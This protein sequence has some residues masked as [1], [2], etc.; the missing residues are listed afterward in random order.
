LPLLGVALLAAAQ[1][2]APVLAARRGERATVREA[3]A[4]LRPGE[5]AGTLLLGGFRGLACDFL[6]LR[7]VNAKQDGR[8][9][10]SVALAQAIVRVQPR[11]EQIWEFLAW[12]LSANLGAEYEA[13]SDKWAWFQE[14]LAANTEG[15]ARNPHSHRLVRHLAWMFFHRGDEFAEE[16]AARRWDT[17]FGPA[18]V[19]VAAQLP[20]AERPA[21]L[22]ETPGLRHFELASRLYD[23]AQRLADARGERQSPFVRRS[24]AI[25]LDHDGNRL[26]AEGQHRAALAR[27]LDALIAWDRVAAWSAERARSGDDL[28]I[29]ALD[30]YATHE[31]RLRRKALSLVRALAPDA[32]A[33]DAAAADLDARRFAALQAR[34][35]AAGW[36]TT[37]VAGR[38]RWLDRQ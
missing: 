20:A 10:E 14:G 11:F 19:A 22:P 30:I 12:D 36:R 24:V 2:L 6:W 33:A 38:I 7:A 26:R 37:A 32:A 4:V 8:H 25:A 18:L 15:I 5:L 29:D 28:A 13:R 1:V 16:I 35:D 9:Y 27:Y 34:L 23:L 31:G 17:L 3:F 21:M